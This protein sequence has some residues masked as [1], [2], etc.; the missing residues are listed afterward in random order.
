MK[1]LGFYDNLGIKINIKAI[2]PFPEQE[3][4]RDN[5]VK[6]SLPSQPDESEDPR[7]PHQGHLPRQS[8]FP[9]GGHAVRL[10]VS[11]VLSEIYWVKGGYGYCFGSRLRVNSL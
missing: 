3:H 11:F 4:P 2:F 6:P 1:R 10:Q 7:C 8:H 9:H 5:L